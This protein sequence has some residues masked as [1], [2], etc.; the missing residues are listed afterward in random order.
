MTFR[1]RKKEILIDILVRLPAKS[2]VRFLCTSKSWSDLIGSSSF[3]CTHLHRNVTIHAHVYLLCLH[4]SNFEWAVDP[5][6]PYVKQELQWSLF[7]NETFEK[8]F[9]LRHP[10]G[11]TE[12]YG[13]YG[14]SNGLVC[15]SDEI[16][17]FDSPIHIWNPSIR[18][19][20]TPPMSTD[21]NIKHS[22]VALQFGFHPRVNDY[23]IVRMMRTNKDA[24]AVE[25]FSLGTDSW[26]MIEAIPP[27]L[28]CTWQHQMST[29]SNGVAYHLLRKGPIFSIMSF[30]SGSE[31]FEEFIAP[32]A[33]CSSWGLCID[34]YKEHICLP[35]RFYGCEEEGMEQVD[36]WV[37]KEKRWKQ[38]CPFIYPRSCY[39]T[40]GISIDNELI[41]Q[42]RDLKKGV[43]YLYLCNYESKQVL[44]TGIK[45]AIITYGEIEFLFSITYIESMV[46]LNDY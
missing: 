33:I 12:H 9:E 38:L 3:V 13:I 10:I 17:N 19:F 40:M 39:R 22:Y 23:K 35:F 6:D 20:R 24:F 25:V 42:K 14:S 21:I 4:P 37:L 41:L 18:K 43:A 7:S 34:V 26:K 32:D 45:L 16:L 2:L 5:D 46:L 15:I 44:E 1:L 30:D 11:S 8:C 31:E 27:W 28:K 29:F 36:L